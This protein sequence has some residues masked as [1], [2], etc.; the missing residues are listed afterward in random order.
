[1]MTADMN[2]ALQ[3]MGNKSRSSHSMTSVRKNCS[4]YRLTTSY[5]KFTTV[6]A[7]ATWVHGR[8]Q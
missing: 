6:N 1:M 7:Y 8:L 4:R 2:L 5:Y 3:L